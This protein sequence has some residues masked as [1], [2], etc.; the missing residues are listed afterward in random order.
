MDAHPTLH[1]TDQT[2]SS[3]GLGKLDDRSADVV[4]KHLEQCPDCRK[5]VSEMS[6][7]SF[8]E[9]V[10]DGQEP[11]GDTTFGQSLLGGAQ[12]DKGESPQAPPPASTLPPGLAEH[13]DYEIKRELGRGGMG[14]VYLAHNKM[15]GRDEVLKV[16]SRQIMERP[17]VLERF[18]REIR[19]VARLRHPNIV[20]AYHATRLRESFVF[21]MEYVEGLD[22]SKMVKAKGAMPVAHACN[23]VYQAALGLQHAHDEGLVHRDIK[24]GN[25][26]LSRKGGKAI[27]KVLDFGLAKATREEKVD[28]A[29]TSEGQALGTPDYI[30]PEQILDAMSADIRADIYSLGGTLYYL[31]AGR[32]PFQANSLYDM[33]QAHISRDAD[34]LNFVRAEVPS[35]LAALVAKMMAK[36]PVR[37]FQ[38][39]ADVARALA[40]FFKRDA[41]LPAPQTF[42]KSRSMP[43]VEPKLD[44]RPGATPGHSAARAAVS[45]PREDAAPKQRDGNVA[46]ER[47][48]Q[49]ADDEPLIE[50]EIPKPAKS[51]AR[52]VPSRRQ[53]GEEWRVALAAA[54]FAVAALGVIVITITTRNGQ[55]KIT[56]K[57]DVPFKIETP[58]VSVEH[59]PEHTATSS[60]ASTTPKESNGM[61][62][63]SGEPA[64]NAWVNLFNGK[65]LDGWE[66]RPEYGGGE[67]NVTDGV[68]EGGGS[69]EG[70]A[71]LV[72][73]RRDF[74]DFRLRV[75]LMYKEPLGT[76]HIQLRRSEAAGKWYGYLVTDGGWWN[77]RQD[78]QRQIAD[79]GWFPAIG[80]VAKH[81][82]RGVYGPWALLSKPVPYT[83][84]H[85]NVIEVTTLTNRISTTVNAITVSE[86]VDDDEPH[87]SGSIA[88]VCNGTWNVRIRSVEIQEIRPL[89]S[90]GSDA[91]PIGTVNGSVGTEMGS[92]QVPRADHDRRVVAVPKPEFGRDPVQRKPSYAS[93][94]E[95]PMGEKVRSHGKASA[96]DGS[97]DTREK[98]PQPANPD[99]ERRLE[100][101]RR[102]AVARMLHHIEVFSEAYTDISGRA[103]AYQN[104]FRDFQPRLQGLVATMEAGT[105]PVDEMQSLS[106]EMKNRN[107]YLLM[108]SGF[109][110]PQAEGRAPMA[111]KDYG[112]AVR[113]LEWTI[114]QF[115]QLNQQ[116]TQGVDPFRAGSVWTSEGGQRPRTVLLVL[117]RSGERFKGRFVTSDEPL[118]FLEIT[119]TIRDRRVSWLG[120]DVVAKVPVQAPDQSGLMNGEVINMEWSGNGLP[121]SGRYVL[122]LWKD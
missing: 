50:L 121:D 113:D 9:R 36:E 81:G 16:M 19:V 88:L 96:L 40:P 18:L 44:S 98:R 45:R 89:A 85:W 35:E 3:Y 64:R 106:V 21:A 2:L 63:R 75:T 43:E 29:L 26:M 57:D 60:R 69:A 49:I 90:G 108:M 41:L 74:R 103:W 86:Y 59:T 30:A 4:N 12:S 66:K 94:P 56:A 7:D 39:P 99:I 71:T 109:E 42:E 32:P 95:G 118:R 37:R 87:A 70:H 23:F 1:P 93:E 120:K 24:P 5:R 73:K 15:M 58:D 82:G 46:W 53:P 83:S 52:N 22:L 33:Y 122:R 13:P 31:L 78:G 77:V 38:T 47:L 97:T 92:P 34:L 100:Q 72:T 102:Q 116:N 62:P 54:A 11:S 114:S 91:A 105:I 80:S 6:A 10:R 17:G 65:D 101:L 48:I 84:P 68:L 55:T 112:P 51:A 28:D 111:W 20:T 107:I 104:C 25:L 27:V 14:V 117:E 115:G 61:I 119:G 76:G 110:S 79:Q 67:W 8:L